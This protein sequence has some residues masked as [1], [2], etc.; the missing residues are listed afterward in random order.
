[1]RERHLTTKKTHDNWYSRQLPGWRTYQRALCGSSISGGSPLC[2]P[3]L[4]MTTLPVNEAW[5][6]NQ[7]VTGSPNGTF[8]ALPSCLSPFPH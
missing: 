3:L 2:T 8:S 6:H 7:I 5:P 1:M 4:S